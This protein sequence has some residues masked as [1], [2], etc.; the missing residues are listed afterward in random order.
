LS[1]S[2]SLPSIFLRYAFCSS[3]NNTIPKDPAFKAEA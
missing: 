2:C 1:A 3:E